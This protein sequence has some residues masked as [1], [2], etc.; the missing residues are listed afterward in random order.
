M[1]V[2]WWSSIRWDRPFGQLESFVGCPSCEP[3]LGVQG[4]SPLN[5]RVIRGV[6]AMTEAS[7]QSFLDLVGI[8]RPAGAL[9]TTSAEAERAALDMGGEVFVLKVQSQ[10]ITHKTEV[11]AVVLNIALDE[12]GAAFDAIWRTA[13]EHQPEAV[14]EGVLVQSQ[15]RPGVE[16]LLGVQVQ[17]H[18]YPPLVTVGLGGTS[19]ELYADLASRTLPLSLKEALE[20][21]QELR[22]WPLLNGY[23]GA[24]LADVESAAR[25]IVATG[26]LCDILGPDLFELEINPLIVHEVGFGVSAVDFVAYRAEPDHQEAA[27][28]GAKES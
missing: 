3:I 20:M 23:R 9:V 16:L 2:G 6:T 8:S 14:I 28:I 24:A 19:V 17:Q 15:V 22:G 5:R 4:S 7:G 10:E 13:H 12:I 21:L 26:P 18:G 11:G 25:A 27:L 1:T